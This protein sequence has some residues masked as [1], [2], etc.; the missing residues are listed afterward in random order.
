[1]AESYEHCPPW[2]LN[3]H[4]HLSGG[5]EGNTK[6]LSKDSRSPVS[7]LTRD[8]TKQECSPLD[9]MFG[10]RCEECEQNVSPNK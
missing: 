4:L 10:V 9:H 5:T 2:S 3:I 1:M 8:V 7:Y 6:N